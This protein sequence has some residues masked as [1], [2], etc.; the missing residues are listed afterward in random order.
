MMNSDADGH[1]V[2]LVGRVSVVSGLLLKEIYLLLLVKGHAKAD[3][4]A[5]AGRI[6]GK[7]IG[8]RE[9]GEAVVEVLVNLQ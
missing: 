3:N 7:A 8:Y 2:A 5:V 4:N 6:I 1:Y 9:G